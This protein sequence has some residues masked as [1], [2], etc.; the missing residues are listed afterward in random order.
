MTAIPAASP[1]LARMIGHLAERFAASFPGRRRGPR[2]IGREAEFP[3][4]WPDG[5]AGDVHLL[6]EPL[7][8]EPGARPS[9]DDPARRDLIVRVD[10]PDAAY[11]VEMGRATVEVVLPPREDLFALSTASRAALARLTRVARRQGLLLL[12]YGIQPRTPAGPGLM[13]PKRRYFALSR[14]AGRPWMYFTSTASDQVQVDI[15]RSELVE[16]VNVMNLL[17]A[18]IIALTANSPV[19]AGRRGKFLSGR[20]GLLATLG[21]SRHGM[22]P[23]R[24]ARLEEFVAFLCVQ[25]CYVLPQGGGFPRF[26]RP[27]TAYLEAHGPRVTEALWRAF[28]WHEHYIWNSARP[29][30]H[31]GT[32]EVRPACQQPPTEPMAAVA[33][34]LGLVEAA[35]RVMVFLQ[36]RLGRDPWPA[37]RAY[38]RAVIRAGPRAPEPS[39][40]LLAALV[41]LAEEGLR[42]RGRN[43]ETFLGP[44]RRRVERRTVPADQAVGLF[45]QGGVPALVEAHKI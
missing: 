7:L 28:L 17:S 22:T 37:M 6:W 34:C 32:I 12:G 33:L 1:R 40:G 30:V 29:R 25:T 8:A 15:T 35:P 39:A 23:R 3:L 10:F 45:R 41:T 38:R 26:G 11:E 9:Y 27:F 31:Y 21:E 14:A 43:E 2:L 19:Y 16:A 44:I 18:P 20:E 24:F 4:V 42:S 13:T 5:R 36:D